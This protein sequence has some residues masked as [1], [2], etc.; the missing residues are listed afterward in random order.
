[1]KENNYEVLISIILPVYNGA[2]HLTECIESLLSQTYKNFELIIVDD[3][4]TDNTPMILRNFTQKD[5]RIKIITHKNNKKQI[6]AGNTALKNT[7]GVYIA[8]MDADDISFPNR[9]EKQI[10]FLQKNLN[11]GI[12]GSWVHIIDNDG[13]HIETMETNTSQGFLGWSLLFDASFVHSS[14][15]MRKEIIIKTGYYQT[16]QAEDYDLWSRV[17]TIANVANLP[18]VLQKKRVWSG[19][20]ALKVPVETFECVLQIMQRNMKLLLNNSSIELETVRAIRTIIEDNKPELKSSLL[21]NASSLI[22]ALY[23]TYI[24]KTNLSITD[25][26]KIDID[27]FQKLYRLSNWQF[28]VSIMN[29]LINKIYLVYHFPKLY[30]YKLLH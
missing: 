16:Q 17:Y 13:K 4:S 24:T 23:N 21:L 30:L 12:L 1:M 28:S 7:T 26:K 19:Q 8:R 29:A 9:L 5:K 20:V 25:K 10:E 14:V 11:V 18:I 27:V 3:G 15:M 2:E 22:K 6:A